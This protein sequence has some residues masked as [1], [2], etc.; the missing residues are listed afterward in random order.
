MLQDIIFYSVPG[1]LKQLFSLES[2]EFT[3]SMGTEIVPEI[4]ISILCNAVSSLPVVSMQ[5]NEID[6]IPAS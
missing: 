1:G 5:L 6:V 3:V 2:D 4:T